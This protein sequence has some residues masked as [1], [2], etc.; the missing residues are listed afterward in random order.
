MVHGYGGCTKD[1]WDH[2]HLCGLNKIEFK[3]ATR[4]PPNSIRR[5]YSCT[6][7]RSN[8]LDANSGFWQI[9]LNK[10]SALLTTFIS[11]FGRFCFNKLPFGITSAPEY[12]Q[13]RMSEILSGLEGIVCMMDD[14]LVYGKCQEEHDQ[15]LTAVL[16]R[17]QKEKVTLNK[18]KCKFSVSHVRFLGHII[19]KSGIHPDPEK[20]EAIQKMPTPKS[21]SDVRRFLGMANQL[22]KF[23]PSLAEISK[24]LRDLSKN[25]MWIWGNAQIEAFQVVKKALSSSPILAFYSPDRETVVAADALSFGVGGVLSQKQLDGSWKPIA[26]ALRALTTTEQRYAQ[27][28]KEILAACYLVLQAV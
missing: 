11:P 3:R 19:N 4:T 12:F 20:L 6:T 24:P 26:F 8:K 23:L 9:H 27:I 17:L 21:V 15:R 13:K 10:D 28:E 5:S 7:G 25:N 16:E 2:T 22:G 1:R 18:E 14:V